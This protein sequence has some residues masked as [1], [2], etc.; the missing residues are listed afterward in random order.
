MDIY[1]YRFGPMG[2]QKGACTAHDSEVPEW[3]SRALPGSSPYRNKVRYRA[4]K[5]LREEGVAR[6]EI[7][8]LLNDGS[9]MRY[10][11]ED[12]EH[13]VREWSQCTPEEAEHVM[14]GGDDS[15][16]RGWFDPWAEEERSLEG[17]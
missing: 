11:A 2:F 5:C 10:A 13:P 3:V 17:Y 14:H 6:V 15:N 4:E 1:V 9:M 12:A 8:V 16:G 7:Y